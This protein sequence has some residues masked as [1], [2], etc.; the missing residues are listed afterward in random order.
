MKSLGGANRGP[1]LEYAPNFGG[2][3]FRL[4]GAYFILRMLGQY[5]PIDK[6]RMSYFI[7]QTLNFCQ[8][9]TYV[10]I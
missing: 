3:T 4:Q 7:L 10:G 2:L 1:T 8:L 6:V 9:I 5:L